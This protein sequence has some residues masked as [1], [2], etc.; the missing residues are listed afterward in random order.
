MILRGL[1]VAL[2][3]ALAG[4]ASAQ[5]ALPFNVGGPYA[6]INQ[7]GAPHT[8]SDPDGLPQL[9]FFGYANCP[10]ICTA[11]LPLMGDVTASLA[12]S[13]ITIRPVMITVDPARDTVENMAEPLSKL[14]PDFIGLTGDAG[15]LDNAYAA[16]SV[17]HALAY[18]DPDYGPV[19][20]H[21]SMIYLMDAAGTVLTLIPPVMDTHHATQVALKYLAPAGSNG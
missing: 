9:L 11:A 13:G 17:D 1:I 7:H 20:T 14:H 2:T 16:F 21:G 5:T 4:P 15:A 12:K 8:Q 3:L 19:Y 10:G 6:L 18:E